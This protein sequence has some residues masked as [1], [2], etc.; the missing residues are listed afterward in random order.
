MK[1][2]SAAANK[3]RPLVLKMKDGSTKPIYCDDHSEN[4]ATFRCLKCGH[5]FGEACVGGE[6]GDKTYCIH[7]KGFYE[8][9]EKRRQAQ[10]K[11]A[12]AAPS[13][14]KAELTLA[15]VGIGLSLAFALYVYQNSGAPVNPEVAEIM[16]VISAEEL[17]EQ[18]ELA[19]A[20]RQLRE[21][22]LEIEQMLRDEDDVN[23]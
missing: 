1:E 19:E 4:Q 13:L 21:I 5:F 9:D 7:C 3:R 20:D 12:T 23:E 10:E 16:Q 15:A 18:R 11:K 8:Q 22:D 17:E 2:K 14:K 6:D